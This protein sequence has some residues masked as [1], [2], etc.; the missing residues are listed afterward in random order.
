[1]TFSRTSAP[2]LAGTAILMLTACSDQPL[3]FDLRGAFGNAPSTAQAAANATAE[4]P[5]P[6]SRGIISYPGYQVAVAQRGDTV[7]SLANRIGVDPGALAR[8]N[9]IQTGD[10]LR[11]GEI[12]ALPGRVSEPSSGPITP[13]GE[14]DITTLAGDA[15]N[16]ASQP[17]S[18]QTSALP[19][20]QSGVEPV[21]H[22]VE[23]GETA[24]T[25][26][27]LYDVSVRSLAEWNGLGSDLSVREGQYLLIPVALPDNG[28]EREATT[29][30]PGAGSPTPQPPSS[31]RALPENDTVPA[32]QPVESSAPD[33]GATQTAASS[34]AA[35]AF[36]VRGDIIRDYAKGENDGIDIAASPGT[37]V[38][39]AAAGVVAAIT[40]DTNGVPIIVIKHPDNLLTVY[41]N[42]DNVTVTKGD[43]VS[44][45]QKLA[46][47]RRDGAAALHFEVRDGFDSV[48]P[49]D[50]LG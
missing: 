22:R 31:S 3:D 1:M 4:R 25:I 42:I 47:I 21:R 14:V 45:G 2:L 29:T 46:E 44:R 35:M 23:R 49:N 37:P 9:G 34:S 20:A 19:S 28:D 16:N 40:Q 41:S 50:Y 38:K 13:S 8:Y 27:R 36:P 48:D 12:V 10:P 6:D 33:L 30:R 18:V 26:A 15:I 17:A 7:A 5:R 43:N 39:A 24:Y 32:A 11:D